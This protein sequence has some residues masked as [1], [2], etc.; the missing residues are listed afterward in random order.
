[1]LSYSV[2]QQTREIGI[3]MAM[4]ARAE[5]VLR[6]VVKQ[7][8]RLAIIGLLLG[9]VLAFIAMYFMSTLLFGVSAHDPAVFVAV[10]L[11]LAIAAFLACYFPAKR[12]ARV[13][14]LVALRHE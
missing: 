12:A 5:N 6:L 4:G 2:T 7:G 9:L 14:P 13:D 11:V 10:T 1:M 3:R 8:M